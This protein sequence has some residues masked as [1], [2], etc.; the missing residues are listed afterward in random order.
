MPILKK[1]LTSEGFVYYN[2]LLYYGKYV[3]KHAFSVPQTDEK[4]KNFF[5]K[6]RGIQP[7]VSGE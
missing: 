3:P 5:R 7:L 4:C 6:R 2:K 1:R